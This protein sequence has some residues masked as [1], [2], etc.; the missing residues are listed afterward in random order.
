MSHALHDEPEPAAVVD[1]LFGEF[2]DCPARTATQCQG[3]PCPGPG[4]YRIRA[5]T[6]A[7]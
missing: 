6:A 2:P 3:D 7:L 5:V 1:D 4:S